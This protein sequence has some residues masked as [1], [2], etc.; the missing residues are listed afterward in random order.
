MFSVTQTEKLIFLYMLVGRA[1]IIN[2]K[3]MT[4]QR[5]QSKSHTF[6]TELLASADTFVK[7]KVSSVNPRLSM[8]EYFYETIH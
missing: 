2:E 8:S 7:S 6:R 4:F 3:A 5:T 1:L